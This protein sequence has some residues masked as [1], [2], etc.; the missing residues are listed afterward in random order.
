MAD[1]DRINVTI[2]VSTV[3]F[4]N[5]ESNFGIITAFIDEV[6]EGEPILDNWGKITL[7]GNMP[8]PRKM[9]SY[10]VEAEEVTD[11]KWGK[12]YQVI[13][14]LTTVLLK[15]DDK[16]GQRKYLE[17]LFTEKQ[18]SDLYEALDDPYKVLIE[19]NVKELV[20]VKGC[21][22]KTAGRMMAKFEKDIFKSRIYVELS[23]YDLSPKMIDRLYNHYKNADIVIE[24][25]KRNPYILMSIH[26]IGWSK[27]DSIAL[28]GGM[29]IY[30]PERIE[31]FLSYYLYTKA[32][33]G[34]TY[35]YSNEQLMPALLETFG[36]EIPDDAIA[37]GIK[38]MGKKI[39]WSDDKEAIG[40]AKYV[41]LEMKT[42]K[43]LIEL[44]NAPN[45]FEYDGWEE[46]IKRKEEEQGWCFT[47][48]QME[49]IKASLENQVVIITGLGGTGKSSIV[50]GVV[51]VLKNYKYA[52]CALS[53]RAAARLAEVT[54]QDGFTIHRLLG[55]PSG[56]DEHQKF[57][58]H[59]DF[60][61]DMDIVILDEISMVDGELFYNLIRALKPGTK[62]IMLGDVGQLES[63]GC[64]NIA[65]DLIESPEIV[66]VILDKIHRQAE[67]SAIITES[68]K[69][70]N[71][72]Q[73]IDKNFAGIVT[74]GEL[75]DLSYDC[76]SDGGNTLYKVMGYVS[77]LHEDGVD[78]MDFQVVVPIK[79]RDAGTWNLNQAIQELCN[80]KAEKEI[81]VDYDKDHNGYIRTGD[82]VI[83]IKNNY[84]ARTYNGQWD[85]DEDETE[86]MGESC[87]IF[88]GNMGIVLDINEK[89]KEAIVDF[90]GIGKVLITKDMMSSIMLGYAVTVHKCQGSE[91]PY[92]IFAMD[93]S[94]Y[95]LLTR[96]L[97]YTAITRAQK[98]CYVVAQ[99]SALRYAVAQNSVINKQTLLQGAL[100][101]AAHPKLVF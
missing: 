15:K 28:K 56:D 64:S 87:P 34:Y 80:E 93:F 58:F 18:V 74:K 19:K 12:Q 62:L 37:A 89:R 101:D 36:D 47:E 60:P 2:Q 5:E 29:G 68:I 78:V 9:G 75:Q 52:Q 44:R 21:G 72:I 50:A 35:L 67:A 16:D 94:S 41:K 31:A 1:G 73:V 66:S 63:I 7:K 92:V 91:F 76:Y 32:Q 17:T 85:V 39:W 90:I 70:R 88:N 99:T 11:K 13:K 95:A 20:K 38:R 81:T 100:Y 49:G 46:V 77:E 4:Y 71:G 84:K 3:R 24:N 8:F 45:E 14:M 65:N 69:A 86:G 61:L 27:C 6:H 59:E 82:K 79:E 98:H 54:G 51:E 55:Y 43:K 48:Q 26:N 22:F 30:S 25:V 42:A 57:V 33:E 97:V 83:N 23:E 53:G 96:Q 10:L 40:L